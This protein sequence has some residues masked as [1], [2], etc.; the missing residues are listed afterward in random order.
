MTMNKINP[1]AAQYAAMNEAY[2][3]FNRK[4][5]N[6]A[7]PDCLIT[8]Q[9]KGG[10][11]GYFAGGRFGTTDGQSITDEI[12]L[13][14]THFKHRTAADVLSTL[15]HEMA[16]L[17]QHHYG[18]V[19][20]GGY[21][22]RE[23]GAKMREIGLIPSST[24]QPGGKETGQRMSHYIEQGGQ[25][26]EH[27][28]DLLRLGFVVPYVELSL[29]DEDKAGK[30]KAKNKT[31]FICGSC[32]AAAWGKPELKIVCAECDEAMTTKNSNYL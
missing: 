17:W 19:S 3:F 22:N 21:H 9:R 20:R 23:W 15:V 27:C 16:H 6:G 14:P 30:S 29:W 8:M 18:Q 24:G 32:G 1:T 13:N 2:A 11:F 12:A 4:L 5:F 26:S 28:E 31:K 7:L 10:T 25:F